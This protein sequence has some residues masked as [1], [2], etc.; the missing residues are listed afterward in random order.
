[1]LERMARAIHD[2]QILSSLAYDDVAPARKTQLRM[3]ARAVLAVLKEPSDVVRAAGQW[4]L[5]NNN[6]ST[7]FCVE[8]N[9]AATKAWAAM[10]AAILEGRG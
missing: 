2:S 9:I 4:V 7:P 5:T 10:I 1:M 3:M 8:A 6:T